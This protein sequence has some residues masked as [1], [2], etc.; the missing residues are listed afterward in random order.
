MKGAKNLAKSIDI[1]D[2]NMSVENIKND[3]LS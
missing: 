3:R 1:V 2:Y